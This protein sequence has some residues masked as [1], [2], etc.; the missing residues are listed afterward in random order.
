M[1]TSREM[2]PRF[3]ARP[4]HSITTVSWFSHGESQ[5]EAGRGAVG[6]AKRRRIEN[7][8]TTEQ[9][10]IRAKIGLLELAKQTPAPHAQ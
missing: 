6:V 1:L 7:T 3:G 9:K 2:L 5:A 8:M 10:I 4:I